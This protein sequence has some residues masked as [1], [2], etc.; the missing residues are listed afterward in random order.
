MTRKR[1]GS[2]SR[3]EDSKSDSDSTDNLFKRDRKRI[4]K[5]HNYSESS[6]SEIDHSVHRPAITGK[7]KGSAS[8]TEDSKSD[9]TDNLFQSGRKHRNGHHNYSESSSSDTG[10]PRHTPTAEVQR[11]VGTEDKGCEL[12]PDDL[13]DASGSSDEEQEVNGDASVSYSC[14][15][16]DGDSCDNLLKTEM[17]SQEVATVS[18]RGDANNNRH[19][20]ECLICSIC[21]EK[22][23]TQLTA[24]TDTCNHTFCAICLQDWS[25]HANICPVDRQTFNFILVRRHL[26]CKII[27]RIPVEPKTQQIPTENYDPLDLICCQVCGEFDREFLILTC[28]CCGSGYHADC[29]DPPLDALPFAEWFCPDCDEINL[30]Y[31]ALRAMPS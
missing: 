25:M 18:E 8:R 10:R 19:L 2:A 3:A 11:T 16:R 28:D 14:N 20:T 22:L 15:E 4:K 9:S 23:T 12:R 26:N 13:D 31:R 1:K 30:I 29:L 27:T 17:E 7:R 6:S 24:T 5:R 21:M